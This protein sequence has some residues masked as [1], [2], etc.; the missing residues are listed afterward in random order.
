[1]LNGGDDIDEPPGFFR[2][3]SPTVQAYQR[4]PGG[5]GDPMS[6]DIEQFRNV[7]IIAHV[8]HGKTTLVDAMLKQSGGLAGRRDTVERVMDSDDLERERGITILGKATSIRWRGKKINIADTPGHA[9]FGGEVERMLTMVDGALLLVDAAEG[10]LPQTRF[11]LSKALSLNLRTIV[12]VN[13]IDRDDARPEEV[14][15]EIYDLFIDLGAG[16]EQI[17]FP[18]LYTNAKAG[19]A[20][21]DPA[22]EGVDLAPL[23]DAIVDQLPPPSGDPSKPLQAL[24]TNIEYNSYIG[25]LGVGRVMQGTLEANQQI[26]LMTVAGERA[27]HLG[28]LFV[29]EGLDKATVDSAPAGELFAV[30]GI[31]DIQIG[32]TVADLAR[33]VALPRV[34]VDEPTIAMFFTTN[35]SPMAGTEGQYVTSRKLWERL[36]REVRGD[37]AL[38]I[39]QTD[40]PD[41]FRVIGRG[42]LALSI[43]IEKMRREGYE[44]CVSNPVVLTKNNDAGEVLEPVEQLVL[45]V[46]N[47]FV[48]VITE[49][50]AFRKGK[51]TNMRPLGASRTRVE[52][53][54]PSRGLIGFRSEL[55]NDTRGQGIMNTLFDG[56]APWHGPIVYRVNGAIV[57]DRAGTTTSYAMFKL[58]PRG[59]LFVGPGTEV[60]EGMIIGEHAKRSDIFVNGCREKKLTN[61]R[62]AGSDQALLLAPRKRMGLEAAIQWISEGELVEVT[63]KTIRI[64][65]R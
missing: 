60:Y 31:D 64:R 35:T 59:V 36:E 11:V 34:R 38:R 19:T 23:L 37:V 54:V 6:A 28:Q 42:E 10:P 65:K 46:P 62:A 3:D 20:T 16:E 15:N 30:A 50:M 41:T 8:D 26:A 32:D 27:A 33:P 29:F 48:G 1:M 45:D 52:F 51:M 49:K 53:R 12:V 5:H 14:L 24:I 39:E 4:A 40:S 55:L 56:W 13:K 22:G 2:V 61:V 17:E 21:T 43:L 25:R 57:A 7:A 58:Q 18:V 44:L 63:P 47:I 9:D